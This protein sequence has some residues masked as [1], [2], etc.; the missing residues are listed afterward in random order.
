[1]TIVVPKNTHQFKGLNYVV[2]FSNTVGNKL[3]YDLCDD[4]DILLKSHYLSRVAN[5]LFSTF[6]N[7][8]PIPL[9]SLFLPIV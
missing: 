1:M 7:I 8:G 2:Q 6:S 4:D 9:S 3:T 5:S